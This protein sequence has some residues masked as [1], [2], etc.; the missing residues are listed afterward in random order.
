MQHIRQTLYR[1]CDLPWRFPDPQFLLVDS[2]L[3]Q[4]LAEVAAALIVRRGRNH[5]IRRAAQLAVK[6]R[7]IVVDRNRRIAQTLVRDDHRQRQAELG[8]IAREF[9]QQ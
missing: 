7:E 4:Q 6:R 3:F 9:R 1:L 8:N 5:M 2:Q